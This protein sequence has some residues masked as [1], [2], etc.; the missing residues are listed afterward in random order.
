MP[1]ASIRFTGMKY[2]LP[3]DRALDPEVITN[4]APGWVIWCL[5]NGFAKHRFPVTAYAAGQA[6]EKNPE[7]A[8]AFTRNGHEI[9]SHAYR[10]GASTCS[11]WFQY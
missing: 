4:T 7:V 9:A 10:E 1:P 8:Q 6:L 3:R 2:H 5:L 11:H